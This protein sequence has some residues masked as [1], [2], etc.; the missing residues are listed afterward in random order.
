MGEMETCLLFIRVGTVFIVW[1]NCIDALC[2]GNRKPR[3]IKHSSHNKKPIVYYAREERRTYGLER[4]KFYSV[5][6]S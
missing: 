6:N 1:K 3:R 2:G 4:E 5:E